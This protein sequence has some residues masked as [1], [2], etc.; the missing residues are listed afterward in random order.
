MP[1][2]STSLPRASTI[3]VA[4]PRFV[5]ERRDPAAADADVAGE[6][7]GR[8]R[9]RAAADDGVEAVIAGGPGG[10]TNGMAGPDGFTVFSPDRAKCTGDVAEKGWRRAPGIIRLAAS[11]A[12]ICPATVAARRQSISRKARTIMPV[13]AWG[14]R[15]HEQIFSVSFPRRWCRLPVPPTRLTFRRECRRRPHQTRWSLSTGAALYRVH[16]WRWLAEHRRTLHR[17]CRHNTDGT[18]A[19]TG[20]VVGLQGQWGNWVLGVE[21]SYTAPLNIKFDSSLGGTADWT[22]AVPAALVIPGSTEFG[23]LAPRSATPSAIGWSMAPAA[24]RAAASKKTPR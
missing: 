3:S 24:M 12:C 11:I 5:A 13:L 7:V 2:G 4:S 18:R 10:F 8:G 23:P 9:D 1:P 20:T 16:P 21:G 19:W 22:F 15:R 6:G 17:G 14:S